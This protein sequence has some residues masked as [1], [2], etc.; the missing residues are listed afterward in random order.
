MFLNFLKNIMPN[1]EKGVSA[2]EMKLPE[3]RELAV[4]LKVFTVEEAAGMKRKELLLAVNKKEEEILNDPSRPGLKRV[5][6]GE[7]TFNGKKVL[8]R[9]PVEVNGKNYEDIVVEGGVTYRE[10]AQ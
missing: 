5:A 4:Y 9:T 1:K 10:L 6:G 3:L 7:D 8:S 2:S